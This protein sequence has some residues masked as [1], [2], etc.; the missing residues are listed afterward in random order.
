MTCLCR[1]RGQV[2]VYGQPLR[3]PAL[4][5]RGWSVTCSGFCTPGKHLFNIVII[6]DI[7]LQFF[8]WW[9][10]ITKSSLSN[11][12]NSRVIFSLFVPISSWAS[13]YTAYPVCILPLMWDSDFHTLTK[14]PVQ[15]YIMSLVASSPLCDSIIVEIRRI[16]VRRNTTVFSNCWSRS[17]ILE[18]HIIVYVFSP[19]F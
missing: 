1:H 13:Y 7:S 2:A 17:P 5:K 8:L 14:Q 11:L 12:P 3:P 9:V 15:L 16:N 19:I 4:V 18:V 6:I 10:Y